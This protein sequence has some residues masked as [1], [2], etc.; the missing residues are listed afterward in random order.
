MPSFFQPL[1]LTIQ[2]IARPADN[3]ADLQAWG[4]RL[5]DYWASG[6]IACNAVNNQWR[7]AL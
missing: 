4:D 6:D 7:C 5:Q 2:V 1:M 3:L